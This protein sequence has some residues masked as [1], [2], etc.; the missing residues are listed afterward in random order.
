MSEIPLVNNNQQCG[1]VDVAAQRLPDHGTELVL[2]SITNTVNSKYI[3]NE[4]FNALIQ[5]N[6][7]IVGSPDQ[8]PNGVYYDGTRIYK[9]L[10]ALAKKLVDNLDKGG[11]VSLPKNKTVCRRGIAKALLARRKW[12]GD[13]EN[14]SFILS[15]EEI[16]GFI[17]ARWSPMAGVGTGGVGATDNDKIRLIGILLSEEHC[18]DYEIINGYHISTGNRADI[19]NPA[20]RTKA[21]WARVAITFNNNEWKVAHPQLWDTASDKPGFVDLDPNDASRFSLIRDGIWLS[22]LYKAIIKDYKVS[23]EKYTK[24]TGGGP[25]DPC[26]YHDWENRPDVTFHRYA[27][28]S[29]LFLTWIYMR[30][31]EI[32]FKLCSKYD[33]IPNGIDG[34]KPQETSP[35]SVSSDSNPKRGGKANGDNA[36]LKAIQDTVQGIS[37]SFK[38]MAKAMTENA[39]ERSNSN[40]TTSQLGDIEKIL[41]QLEVASRLK[42]TYD[43]LPETTPHEK[44]AKQFRLQQ[45]AMME[46]QLLKSVGNMN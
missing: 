39:V 27:D 26:D 19:D 12:I 45:I 21:A 44:Q 15:Q 28:E 36:A 14:G 42:R 16:V 7:E 29:K 2:G 18:L 33:E 22:N 40:S 5:D 32:G 17:C 37:T 23:F 30:D 43:Q 6:G 41:N 34:G 25:G 8:V 46:E 38:E 31:K 3:D 35:L 20:M 13:A 9:D 24:G 11:F 1:A 4:T 10:Y